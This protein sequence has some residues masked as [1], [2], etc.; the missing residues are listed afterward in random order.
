MA[1][2]LDLVPVFPAPFATGRLDDHAAIDAE[3][4][5]LLLQLRSTAAPRGAAPARWESPPDL[6]DRTAPVLRRLKGEVLDTVA[7]LV[8]ELGTYSDT[9]LAGLRTQSR[10][11]GTIVEPGHGVPIRSHSMASWC[12]IYCAQAP[13]HAPERPNGGALS[14]YDPRLGNM[15][16]DA[17]NSRLRMPFTFGHFATR[18]VAGQL[19][20]FPAWLAYETMPLRG[21]TPLVT[22]TALLRFVGEG[23]PR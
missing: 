7:T 3:L 22:V 13:D 8:A 20:V 19:A 23:G 5:P 17:G 2:K 1:A 4:V 6:W 12:A 11:W 9:E 14:L 21:A 16:Q 10:A 15:Y 18:A